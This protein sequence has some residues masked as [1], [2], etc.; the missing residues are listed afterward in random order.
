MARQWL[1]R[2]MRLVGCGGEI[3]LL[4]D[5]A[6]ELQTRLRQTSREE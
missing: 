6:T 5:R 3:N 1:D 2:G 4:L